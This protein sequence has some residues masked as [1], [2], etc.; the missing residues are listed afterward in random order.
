[1]A[2]GNT[3]YDAAERFAS[4]VPGAEIDGIPDVGH[5][6][7]LDIPERYWSGLIEFLDRHAPR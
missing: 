1:M 4:A 7:M 6:A 5:F 3:V 2:D